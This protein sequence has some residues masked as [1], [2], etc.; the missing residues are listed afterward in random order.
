MTKIVDLSAIRDS[1]KAENRY[2]Y[3]CQC[4]NQTFWLRPDAKVQCFSCGLIG[5]RLI[6]GEF[7]RSE[8]INPPDQV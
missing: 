1:H 5:P 2:C 6:W 4:G 7:F 8:R 3:E